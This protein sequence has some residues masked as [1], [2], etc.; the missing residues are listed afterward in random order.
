MEHRGLHH[1]LRC[2]WYRDGRRN[3]ALIVGRL[4]AFWL[5]DRQQY[6]LHFQLSS[7]ALLCRILRRVRAGAQLVLGNAT[8][9]DLSVSP[10]VGCAGWYRPYIRRTPGTQAFALVADSRG[11]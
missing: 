11:L 8:Q 4:V 5:S 9:Q 6:A 1:R 10:G 2:A 3:A 7:A